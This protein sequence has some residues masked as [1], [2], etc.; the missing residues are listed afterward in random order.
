MTQLG[1]LLETFNRLLYISEVLMDLVEKQ[2]K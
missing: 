1:F 2:S